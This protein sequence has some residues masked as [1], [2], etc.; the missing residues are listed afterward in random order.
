MSYRFPFGLFTTEKL[1]SCGSAHRS[2]LH[3]LSLRRTGG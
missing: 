1:K 2:G 3:M